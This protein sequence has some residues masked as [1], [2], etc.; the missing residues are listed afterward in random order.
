MR[1]EHLPKLCTAPLPGLQVDTI[2]WVAE[3]AI[4]VSSKLLSGGAEEPFAP[5]CMLTWQGA[6]P[7]QEGLKLSGGHGALLAAAQYGA[8]QTA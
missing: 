4:L 7:T 2:S 3:S 6:E 1:T 5:L 8:M